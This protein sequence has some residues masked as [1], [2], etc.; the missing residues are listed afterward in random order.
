[1]TSAFIGATVLVV[2][3]SLWVRRDTWWSRWE[4][5]ITSAIALEGCALVLLSPW[6]AQAVGPWLHKASGIWNLQQMVGHIFIVMAIAANIYHVMARLADFEEMRTLYRRQVK[7]PARIGLPAMMAVFVIADADYRPD[8]FATSSQGGWVTAY[9]VLLCGLLIYESAYATRLLMMV[10][11]D[12]RAK[13]TVELYTAS[14]AFALAAL[15]AQL[16]TT[17]TQT[18]VSSLV[19]LWVCVSVGIFAYGSARSWRAKAAW[20]TAG[21]RPIAQNNPPQTLS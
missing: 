15:T 1:M 14:S 19:W 10:R 13:E 4:I 5:G 2:L 18:D 12:P 11:S 7:W 9:W 20:F 21:H 17:W 8:G 16:S 3:Y 6:A